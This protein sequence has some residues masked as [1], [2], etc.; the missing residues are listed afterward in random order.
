MAE[1]NR[2]D[3]HSPAEG[4]YNGFSNIDRRDATYHGDRHAKGVRPR[5]PPK[6]SRCCLCYQTDAEGPIWWHNEDYRFPLDSFTICPWC[7]WMVHYRWKH[8]LVWARYVAYL[9]VGFAPPPAFRGVS[10]HDWRR[11][12]RDVN[13]DDWPMRS[14]TRR[15]EPGLLEAL[16]DDVP[17][18]LPVA[19]RV[20]VS[21]H[22]PDQWSTGEP[23][24]VEWTPD[25]ALGWLR[26]A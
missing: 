18:E 11:T 20:D 5:F 22:L 24:T 7:H 16:T 19:L 10:W 13:P 12:F 3:R 25:R 8:P 17:N 23:P 15:R 1:R 21:G 6:G 2:Y 4:S 14:L 26:N 9:N